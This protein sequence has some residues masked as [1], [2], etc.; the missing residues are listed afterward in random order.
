VNK[1][2]PCCGSS[3]N[4]V[5][6]EAKETPVHSVLLVD[7]EHEA[8][9]FP[10]GSIELAFCENCGFIFNTQFDANKLAYS[11]NYEETQSY[12]RRFQHFHRKLALDLIARHGLR[13]K[14]IC[15]IGCGKGEFISLLCEL[16]PNKGVGFDP[17]Y[18]PE[19]NQS[20]AKKNIQFIQEFFSEKNAGF[21]GDFVCCKMTLEHISQVNQFITMLRRAIGSRQ[22]TVFFQV[23]DVGRILQEG[24]FWDIYYEHCSYFSLGSLARLFCFC[25]FETSTLF[26]GFN[27][28]YLMIEARPNTTD[29][30]NLLEQE[31]DI[32]RLKEKITS[33]SKTFEDNIDYWKQVLKEGQRTV[34]WGAGSKAVAFLT[35]MDERKQIS[36]AVDINPYKQGKYLPGT[37]QKVVSPDFLKQYE[38]DSVIVMNPIYEEEIKQ[39]LTTMGLC[40]N[41]T[42]L[43]KVF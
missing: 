4:I 26:K 33:F 2:C 11:S 12:S 25:G 40:P 17:A 35:T 5:F 15:E 32:L 14:N 18:I 13:N 36:Y 24:A 7:S 29:T 9:N 3:D 19:R 23:P 20:S 28:Q 34:L 42:A 30:Q 38:P 1:N 21:L 27:A 31:N 8:S 6:Y 10:K 41:I 39:Q 43:G 16:G 22:L 37:A